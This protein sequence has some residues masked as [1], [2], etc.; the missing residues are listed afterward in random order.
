MG[1]VH[2]KFTYNSEIDF[3]E[4]IEFDGISAGIE[5][6]NKDN[7][8]IEGDVTGVALDD[9][10]SLPVFV[11]S[12]GKKGRTW[13]L[14]VTF[15]SKK[16]LVFPIEGTINDNGFFTLNKRYKLQP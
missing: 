7:F 12:S 4:S 1:K 9:E 14:E 15:D 3:P 2:Y 13:Q 6:D 5:N 16:L 10:E 11:S 8:V